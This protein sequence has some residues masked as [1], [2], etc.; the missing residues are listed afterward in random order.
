VKTSLNSLPPSFRTYL[1]T[2][3]EFLALVAPIICLLDCAVL[4]FLPALLPIV[5]MHHLVHGVGD[6]VLTLVVLAL[7]CPAIIPGF[8]KHRNPRI[9]A[10]FGLAA[11]LMLFINILSPVL[12]Q[13]LHMT[14]TVISSGLLIKANLDNR[15]LLACACV[16]AEAQED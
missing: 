2:A 13:V 3:T 12:D 15:K 5:G 1:R 9:L 11:F 16:R 10:M 4:P 7:C 14:L 6:Q 8:L